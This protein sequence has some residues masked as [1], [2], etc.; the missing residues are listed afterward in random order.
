MAGIL[1]KIKTIL[2][3]EVGLDL[4]PPDVISAEVST[5]F[6]R[7]FAYVVGKGPESGIL[8]EST[9]DGRLHVAAAGTS[10]EVYSVESGDAEDAFAAADT[11]EF[12]NA[13]YV[14]DFLIETFG[15]TIQ[16]RNALNDWGDNKSLPVGAFS[17][18]LIHYGVRIQNRGAGNVC[19][20]EITT[21]R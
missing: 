17:I 8:I 14:T 4:E 20:Y 19:D 3:P 9:T 21:Y 5:D 2:L 18:E 12:V 15:A 13:Q 16:W 7:T 10:M 11:F 1:Q 6:T